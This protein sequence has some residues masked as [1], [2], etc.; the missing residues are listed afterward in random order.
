MKITTQLYIILFT[1]V[2]LQSCVKLDLYQRDA[3][4]SGDW[5]RAEDQFRQSVNEFYRS[6]FWLR[7]DPNRSGWTDNF[8]RRLEVYDIKGGTVA[9]DYSVSS[10]NWFT[11]YK[12]ITRTNEVAE[13]LL[14][15]RE[16]LGE[17][18][19]NQFLA[20][21]NFFRAGF[22]TYLITH[23]GDVPFY[24][25][26]ISVD[27]SFT[28]ART[29]KE[30]ILEKVFAY[31]DYAAQHLPVSYAG[32]QYAT[33][34]AA[35]ALKARA[36]IYMGNYT[37]AAEAAE[38]C[39]GLGV[40]ELHPGFADLF[41]SKTKNSKEVIFQIPRSV[42][43]NVV[44]PVAIP[45]GYLPRNHGGIA[46]RNPTWALLASFEC[47]DGLL[48]DQSPLFD[49]RNPFK[50]RDPRCAMT[51]VPFGSLK[52]GDGLTEQSGFRYM[53]IEYNPYPRRKQ[54]MNFR[55]GSLIT[56][57]DTRS[58][59][60]Y[61]TF[62]GLLWRKE[63]DEDWIDFTT[64]PNQIIIRYADVLLMYAEAKTELN[65]I[66]QS[67]LQAINTVRE[68]AYANSDIAAPPVTTHN[69][70]ELRLK[71]RNER[72]VELAGEGLRYMDLIRWR[73]AHKALRG[74]VY[75]LSNVAVNTN[76]NVTP[77][78]PLMENVVNKGLW[79][80]GMRPEIDADGLPNFDKLYEANLCRVLN[81]MNFP[82]RQYLWPIPAKELLLNPNL[83]QN[84]G[85]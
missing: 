55:N 6:D 37:V 17:T 56:N 9:S 58:V 2:S 48:I 31:Y 10:N 49:P 12:G 72:R 79:F 19:Y 22:W 41:L 36:A 25:A 82:E 65:Q 34:G 83:I 59:N 38:A 4:N 71:V 77:T 64:A 3:A 40:Y 43:L 50:N 67:V 24:E 51:I 14:A 29:P 78:G 23:Y 85:Y 66:D 68:R 30:E 33:K 76:V 62:N 13:K 27:E 1:V 46:S 5:Y 20:E 16:T 73:I 26:P 42:E 45:E 35:L 53:D 28:I 69:Q 75:G 60:A 32:V 39:M 15:Q 80:W 7:D 44:H 61:A 54:V 21:V 84:P 8:Q 47:I 70:N 57:H 52:E 18:A 81:V 63:V 11:M 74:N